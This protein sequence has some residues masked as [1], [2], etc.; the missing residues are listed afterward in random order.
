MPTNSSAS[1]AKSPQVVASVVPLVPAWRVDRAFDYALGTSGAA[2]GSLVRIPFGGRR[3]RGIVVAIRERITERA[4]EEI[5]GAVT[6][7]PLMPAPV[8]ELYEW[9][10]ER[11]VTPRGKAFARVVPPRVRVAPDPAHA[12]ISALPSSILE[13]YEAGPALLAHLRAGRGGVHCIQVLPGTDRGTL[14]AEL[15]AAVHGPAIVAVPE[16]RYGSLVI[17]ALG[18]RIEGL[19]RVDSGIAEGDRARGWLAFAAG[20]TVAVGGRAAVLAPSPDLA[21]IVID[22]EHH[23]TYKED[24]APRYHAVK[25][26]RERARIQDAACV[27]VSTTPSVE[28]AWITKSSGGH[29]VEPRRADRRRA[30]PLIELV[31]RPADRSLSAELHARIA[32]RLRDGQRVALLAPTGVY[33]RAVWCSSCH[34]SLRCPLCDAGLFYERAPSTVRCV[35]CGYRSAAPDACPSCGASDFRFVGAG[36]ERLGEQLAK[37]FP[38]ATVVR[39]DPSAPSDAATA[40]AQIYVTTWAGTKRELRPDVSLVG[41]LDADWLLRR[42]DFRAA[43]SGYQALV[44]MA[45][46][47]GPA[48]RGGQLVVQTADPGHHAIQALVRADYAFFYERELAIRRELAYP[49]FSELIRISAAGDDALTAVRAIVESLAHHDLVV[50]GPVRRTAP[51]GAEAL[52][53]CRSAQEVARELRAILSSKRTT[54]MVDVDPR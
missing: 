23:H 1:Q 34:L 37:A 39:V 27:L 24:R 15:L 30:R 8:L 28:S 44:E 21:L 12:T 43:E 49:P 26:A 51:V 36:S 33:A 22:E 38:R 4:L 20:S 31:T 35:R 16:V 52:L 29:W 19:V 5:S 11:Y 42:P 2:V 47:A 7:V 18:D 6:T 25:V 45:E 48:D 3:V 13:D 10:A 40:E 54:V 53:K 41:V 32:D 9:L 46:W 14:I 17:D 50:L